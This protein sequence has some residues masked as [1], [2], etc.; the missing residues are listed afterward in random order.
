MPDQQSQTI[1]AAATCATPG[2]PI[3]IRVDYAWDG[4]NPLEALDRRAAMAQLVSAAL[5]RAGLGAEDDSAMGT[6]RCKTVFAVTDADA[7]IALIEKTLKRSVFADYQ[8]I[9]P[10]DAPL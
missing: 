9:A 6:K 3:Y 4:E 10:M 8:R 7:A 5:N 1:G 2:M